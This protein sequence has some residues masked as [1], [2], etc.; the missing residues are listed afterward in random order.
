MGRLSK[1]RAHKSPNTSDNNNSVI[2]YSPCSDTP[3]E[4]DNVGI[5]LTPHLMLDDSVSNLIMSSTSRSKSIDNIKSELN[6]VFKQLTDMRSKVESLASSL[7][8]HDDLKQEIKTLSPL[9]LLLS[10]D[11]VPA[12]LGDII[13]AESVIDFIANEVTKRIISPERLKESERLICA[14]TKFR[15]ARVVSDKTT[16]QRLT[17]KRTL[18]ENKDV[19]ITTNHDASAPRSTD[20]ATLSHVLQHS[21]IPTKNAD[22]PVMSVVTSDSQCT[23]TDV[24]SPILLSLP[25]EAHKQVLSSNA[26]T[27]TNVVKIK[28]PLPHRKNVSTEPSGSRPNIK[29]TTMT[30]PNKNKTVLPDTMLHLTLRKGGFKGRLGSNVSQYGHCNHY[31]SRPNT[32]QTTMNQRTLRLSSNVLNNI[33]VRRNYSQH[34]PIGQDGLLGY[35]TSNVLN[36]KPVRRNFHQQFSIG[37]DGLLGYAPLTQPQLAGACLNCPPNQVQQINP[38]YQNND[39]FGLQKSLVPLAMQFVQAIAHTISQT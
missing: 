37:Q 28:I 19:E 7:S 15:N 18:N 25:L 22:L 1:K 35:S 20:A 5:G 23:S 39:F 29:N 33:P 26:T 11:I 38:L 14:L 36:N 21:D 6:T 3:F 4:A 2:T 13:K 10:K 34:F 30:I 12:E 9:K 8:K 17:Q 32:G 16:N 27:L 31:V 24:T